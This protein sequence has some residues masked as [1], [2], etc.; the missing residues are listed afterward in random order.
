MRSALRRCPRTTAP[1][2]MPLEKVTYWAYQ[3]QDLS[4][5]GA[6]D[7]LVNSHYDMLVLEPTR[8]DWSSDDRYF[9]TGRWSPG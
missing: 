2:P 8:T 7:A 9:D 1:A 6:V 3:L 4:M 5:P